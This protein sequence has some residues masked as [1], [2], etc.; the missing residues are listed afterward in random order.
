MRLRDSMI[1]TKMQLGFMTI[2]VLLILAM[3]IMMTSISKK[4]I[5]ENIG[6]Y[7]TILNQ[8]AI[9]SVKV[10]LQFDDRLELASSL[11]PFIQQ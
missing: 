10:G 11:E 8:T 3:M 4:V 2:S 6:P 5:H 7:Q 1:K 9:Q